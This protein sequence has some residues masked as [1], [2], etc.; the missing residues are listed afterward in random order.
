MRGREVP[1]LQA[2]STQ[3]ISSRTV[4]SLTVNIHLIKYPACCCDS[5]GVDAIVETQ[6]R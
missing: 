4:V 5:N 1:I 3:A 2:Q 6:T